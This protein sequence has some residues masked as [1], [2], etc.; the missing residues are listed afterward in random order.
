MELRRPHRTEEG[1]VRLWAEK[2]LGLCAQIDDNEVLAEYC[3]PV[4]ETLD[5]LVHDRRI[6]VMGERGSGKST[7]LAALAGAPVIARTRTEAQQYTCWRFTCGDG[8]ATHSRFIPLQNLEGLELV[9]TADIRRE[10]V[11]QTCEILMSGADVILGVLDARTAETSPLW[12][13][14]AGVSPE[15]RSSWMLVA[16]QADQLEAKQAIALKQRLRELAAEHAV[17]GVRILIFPGAENAAVQTLRGCVVEMLQESDG[18][19]S[20]VRLLA[21]RTMDMVQQADRVLDRRDSASRKDNVFMSNIE[22]E[23][24]NFLQHQITGLGEYSR[25]VQQTM[26]QVMPELRED[27]RRGMGSLLSPVVLL[28]LGNLGGNMDRVIY[29]S[30]NDAVEQMEQESDKQFISQCASHWRSV[31]PRMKKNLE[32]E[33]GDFPD[34]DLERDLNTLRERLCR[35]LYEPIAA[36]GMRARLIRI[37]TAHAGW[38]QMCITAICVCLTL[39]GI[40]GFLGQDVPGLC[41]VALAGLVWCG[42]CIAHAVTVRRV[43]AQVN[44]LMEEACA[45][46]Y[47]VIKAVLEG[48]ITSRVTAYRQLYTQPRQKLARQEVKLKPLQEMQREIY[49]QVRVL[50]P[51][52]RQ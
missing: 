26:L 49:T 41:C 12:E 2:G 33:I 28:Q 21:E 23:I 20:L 42:G 24:D 40:L 29:R 3:E 35:E 19:P 10:D 32:C 45:G 37:F 14:L 7:V 15:E 17:M 4:Q 44:T 39:G 46:V 11:R 51:H 6:L 52:L 8:D 31:R 1:L 30:L 36:T 34:G 5:A 9:D 27:V 13:M 47:G 50:L 18:L 48:F 16:A 25:G 22:Q 38:M 43:C